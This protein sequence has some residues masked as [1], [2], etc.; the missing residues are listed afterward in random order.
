MGIPQAVSQGLH[1]LFRRRQRWVQSC[2]A[3]ETHL[4]AFN[5][6]SNPE[7]LRVRRTAPGTKGAK[8][9]KCKA[10]GPQL[11]GILL[12]VLVSSAKKRFTKIS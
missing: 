9:K 11:L 3:T 6:L 7:G 5:V 12:A 2:S 8:Q 4:R 10:A 1:G